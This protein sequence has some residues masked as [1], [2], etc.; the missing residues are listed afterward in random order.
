[1]SS[2]LWEVHFAVVNEALQER[3]SVIHPLGKAYGLVNPKSLGYLFA[4]TN[5]LIKLDSDREWISPYSDVVEILDVYQ[6]HFR[7]LGESIEFGSS[8]LLWDLIHLIKHIAGTV[9]Q[10]IGDP[11]RPDRDDEQ[12][13][14]DKLGWV[15][16]FFWVAFHRKKSVD[17]RRAD[18]ACDTLAYIGILFFERGYPD[19]LESNVS[20]I[21][22]IIKS[23]CQIAK[24][25][26]EY[27]VGDL[28]AHLWCLRELVEARDNAELINVIDAALNSKP[29]SL[30]QEQWQEIQRTIELRRGQLMERLGD[31]NR[32]YGSDTSEELLQR[33]LAQ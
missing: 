1:M 14:V 8:F 12:V 26:D 18:E 27:A 15:M 31:I 5:V 2:K 29:E 20:H 30:S 28:F 21:V 24:P 22:S 7:K 11:I 13:L 25:L 6:R 16:S 17:A 19:V 33:V 23:Y 32:R 9:A 10:M 3:L 4:K